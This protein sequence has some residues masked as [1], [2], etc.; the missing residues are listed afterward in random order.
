MIRRNMPARKLAR[1]LA[2]TARS[3][4]KGG[5]TARE[6][7]DSPSKH[8]KELLTQARSIRTKQVR[9]SHFGY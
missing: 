2:A 4:A 8:E 7:L 6:I 3:G 5:T 9:T 1:Q